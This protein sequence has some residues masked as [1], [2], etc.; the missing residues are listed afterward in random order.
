MPN[1]NPIEKLSLPSPPEDILKIAKNLPFGK[2]I[3]DLKK[4]AV[5]F[6]EEQIE[7]LRKE[8]IKKIQD[9]RKSSLVC[10][11]S[12]TMLDPEDAQQFY[13]VLST[14]PN[15]IINL[16]LF[17]LSPGGYSDPA[18]K[19]SRMCQEFVLKSGGKFSV[20][21][22]YYAKSAAT[23]LALG[24]NEIV[25]GPPSELGPIDPQGIIKDKTGIRN[26]SL[27]ALSDALEFI[28]KQVKED[29]SR[30]AIY[31]PLIEQVDLISLG[32]YERE[33]QSARQYAIQLLR[34]RMFS[35]KEE[36]AEKTAEL[37]V[38]YY[39][40][41]GYVIDR[42][43]ARK[44]LNLN[45]VDATEE[46]WEAMWKLHKIYDDM[47]REEYFVQEVPIKILETERLYLTRV[48]ER[49]DDVFFG[50]KED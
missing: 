36:E 3:E 9:I 24:A 10:F 20:L 17:I 47:V 50:S 45:V 39:K 15:D 35:N 40:S 2:E 23:I 11:Y 7:N 13:E 27:L 26:V 33:I 4:Q 41:H 18:F 22:P 31:W 29:P 19:I 30:A 28:N 49:L 5:L 32:D 16:D 42:N 46:E 43:E 1:R 21:I 34:E 6:A 48:D 12:W 37:L 38:N 44:N 8:L 25:M 14:L